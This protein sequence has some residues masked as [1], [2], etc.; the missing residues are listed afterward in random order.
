M[1]A[2]LLLL[3]GVSMGRPAACGLKSSSCA[4]GAKARQHGGVQEGGTGV[5]VQRMRQWAKGAQDRLR[6]VEGES[7]HLDKSGE[8]S[9]NSKYCI[10]K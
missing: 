6:G 4:A 8:N 10:P 1:L 7:N 3:E 2:E 9:S 5:K